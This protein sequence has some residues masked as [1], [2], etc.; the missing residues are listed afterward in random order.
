MEMDLRCE[1]RCRMAMRPAN[2][3]DEISTLNLKPVA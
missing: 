1:T 3:G 2:G